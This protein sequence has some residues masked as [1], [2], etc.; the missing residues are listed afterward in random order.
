MADISKITD[1]NGVT[2]DIKDASARTALAAKQDILIFDMAPTENSTNPVTSGGVYQALQNIDLSDYLPLSGGTM[3]GAITLHTTGF[4]TAHEAGYSVN[5]Y[6]NFTH[7]RTNSSDTWGIIGANGNALT[8]AFDTGATTAAGTI[9][10]PTMVCT[11]AKPQCIEISGMSTSAGHGGFIDFHFNN[12]SADYTSRIIESAS[13]T[14][15]VYGAISTNNTLTTASYVYGQQGLYGGNGLV[16]TRGSN[17]QFVFQN[18]SAQACGEIW[19]NAGRIYIRERPSANAGNYTDIV[20]PAA[21]TGA[22]ANKYVYTSDNFS[23]SGT[24]LTITP[25]S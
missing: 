4:Y 24:T 18:A 22:N 11:T 20:F 8:V 1:I 6:G 14:L 17:P 25:P 16:V 12:S 21:K 5:Q 2:Y 7:R 23:L 19:S 9:T 10:A 3:T 13:G 15:T